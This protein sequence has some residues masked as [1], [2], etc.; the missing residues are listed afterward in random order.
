MGKLFT[1]V[2]NKRLQPFAEKYEKISECQAGFRKSFSTTDHVF[3]LH[4][5]INLLQCSKKK[6]FCSFIDLKGAFDSV[7]RKGLLYK[8][9]Q[10]N[11]MG[12]CYELIK[13]IYKSINSCVSVNNICSNYFPSNIGVRQGENLSSFLFSVLLND[14]ET[15]FSSSNS[16]NGIDCCRK[17][18][19]N[20]I[21]I[22]LKIFVLL[23]A[24][25]T[26][27]LANSPNELQTARSV[28]KLLQ[29]LE[30]RK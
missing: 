21:F 13:N 27:I 10:F 30:T 19:E 9:N 28:F 17:Q 16:F 15:Y 20:N 22:F 24:D 26:V 8:I 11:I 4:I 23:Y 7:W 1:S 6:L 3:A 25:D 18:S 5:L 29:A 2:I 12:K 14:I